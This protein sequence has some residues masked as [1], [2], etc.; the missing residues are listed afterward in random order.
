MS[1]VFREILERTQR[2]GIVSYLGVM[3]R[4]RPDDFLLSHALDGY[5]LAL[6]FPVT[7]NNRESLWRLCAELSERVLEAGGRF[8]PAKDSVMR[9]QDFARSVGEPALARF[10]AL[11]AEHDPERILHTDLAERVG[12]TGGAR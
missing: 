7:R 11:R 2:A 3:K 4:Y 6:D 5:S 9:P 1:A 12:L 8:Y 10:E